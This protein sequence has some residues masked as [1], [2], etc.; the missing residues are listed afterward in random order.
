M[1]NEIKAKYPTEPLKCW[2]KVNELREN[3]YRDYATAH[4]KGGIR[5]SGGAAGIEAVPAGFGG[6]IYPL[7]GEPYGASIA[8]DREFAAKCHAAAEEAGYPRDLCAYMRN[9]WG[10][11]LLDTYAFG[12]PYPEPDF[13]WQ[14]HMCCSH[15][16]WYQEAARLE[17]KDT[18]VFVVDLSSGPYWSLNK[19]TGHFYANPSEHQARYIVN[20]IYEH[21]ERL[22]KILDRPYHDELLFEAAQNHFENIA[23]WPE[24]CVL[25]QAIPAPLDQKSMFSQ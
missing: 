22:E 23:I 3:Y 24:I 18:P 10:S 17:G 15:G 12:G 11:K 16:K 14:F 2:G 6:D 8:F 5:W 9:Y 19:E 13:Y 7:T 1:E 21:L 25:N 20:Q 4:E